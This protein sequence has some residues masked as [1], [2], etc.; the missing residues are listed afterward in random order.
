[1]SD[2]EIEGNVTV[3]AEGLRLVVEDVG[4]LGVLNQRLRGDTP[5]IEAH[6]APILLLDDG[7]LLT[8]LGC[9]DG[10][11]VATRARAEYY[12]VI[13]LITHALQNT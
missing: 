11:D 1:M 9:A 2:P 8:K 13:M 6:A 5:N 12:N 3:D 7:N 10:G 4:N